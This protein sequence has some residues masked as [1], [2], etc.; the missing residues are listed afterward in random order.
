[1]FIARPIFFV[2]IA[3][4]GMALAAGAD[5]SCP[6]LP[7]DH[8]PLGFQRRTNGDRCE[9]FFKS[10]VSG[11][12]LTVA[13][14]MSGRLPDSGSVE[15]SGA[16]P[17][18]EI[19]VRAV[20]L[21]LGTYYRMDAVITPEKPLRWPLSE[22]VNASRSLKNADLGLY[23]WFGDPGRPIYV[24]VR[25]MVPGEPPASA[26][27]QAVRLGVRANVR[28]AVLTYSFADESCRFRGTDWKRLSANVGSGAV[29]TL[30]LP[31]DRPELCVGFR[32]T[33][34]DSDQP[35]PLTIRVRL[36]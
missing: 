31:G 9:G 28:L 17:K 15:V 3:G 23:G 5:P 21:P 25:A 35:E 24:P 29:R 13:F 14:L 32:A 10:N 36:R 1:L 6:N 7:P 12:A 2:L 30:E 11:E 26:G 27:A 16:G 34:A 19:N 20:A 18:R 22:V 33:I 4:A 8:G